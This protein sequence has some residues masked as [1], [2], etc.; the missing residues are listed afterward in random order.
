MTR[1]ILFLWANIVLSIFNIYLYITQILCVISNTRKWKNMKCTKSLF[2][3]LC[4]DLE[5]PLRLIRRGKSSLLEW[6][7]L[8]NPSKLTSLTS[9]PNY[10]SHRSLS[11]SYTNSANYN[12]NRTLR[13]LTSSTSDSY[14]F[15]C[16]FNG[17]SLRWMGLV[18]PN[19]FCYS[20]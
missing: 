15:R 9:L 11:L 5:V 10:R 3:S 12:V 16:G 1:V 18:F 17:V 13:K 6:M 8:P 20:S 2:S 14:F 7:C 19:H 4:R